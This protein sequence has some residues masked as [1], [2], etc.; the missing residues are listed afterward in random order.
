MKDR[1]R[2]R[3]NRRCKE[4][5]LDIRD[6]TGVLDPTPY[7]AVLNMRNGYYYARKQKSGRKEVQMN[8]EPGTV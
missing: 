5:K 1:K 8:G 2:Q 3:E 7:Y 6:Y 4:E